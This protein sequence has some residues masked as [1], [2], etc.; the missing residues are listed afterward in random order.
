MGKIKVEIDIILDLQTPTSDLIGANITHKILMVQND[1]KA[2]IITFSRYKRVAATHV[3]TSPAET[4]KS[5]IAAVARS[6]IKN[7]VQEMV[8]MEMEVVGKCCF[9]DVLLH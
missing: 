9:I 1:L 8:N 2:F 3:W 7:L 6:L 5:L 4:N